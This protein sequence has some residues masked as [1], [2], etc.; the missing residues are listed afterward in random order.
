MPSKPKPEKPTLSLLR[1]GRQFTFDELMELFEKVAGRKPTEA[2]LEEA[3]AEF[4]RKQPSPD[5]ENPS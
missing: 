5:T 2:E 1:G 4:G 3:R